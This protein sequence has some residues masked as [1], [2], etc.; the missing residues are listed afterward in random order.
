MGE[1]YPAGRGLGAGKKNPGHD[2]PPA[3]GGG[4]D[5]VRGPAAPGD[6]RVELRGVAPVG[7]DQRFGSAG[8]LFSLW[9][10]AQISPSTFFVGVL[11]TAGFIG[12]GWRLGLVAIVAGNVL[13]S[14][15]VAVLGVLGTRTGAPQL[16]QSRF[17]FGRGV[18]LPAALTWITQIG[19]EA[20]A[21]IFGAE[22]LTVLLGLNYYLGLLVTFAVMGLI[23]VVGYEAIHLFEKLMAVLLGVLFAVVTAKTFLQHPAVTATT[24]GGAAAGGFVLMLAIVFG[25]AVSWGPVSSDYSRYLPEGTSG[26]RIWLA[27]FL[28]LVLGMSWIEIL[29]FGASVLVR[30]V[31]SMAAVDAIMGGG[32]LGDVAMVAMFL[33]TVAILCV[34]DYSGALAAQAAGVPLVR[35]LIT[36]IAAAVAY[37]AAAWLNTGSLGAKFEDVLLLISYWITPWTAIVLLDWWRHSRHLAPGRRRRVLAGPFRSLPMGGR[38]WGATVGLVAGFFACIPFSDTAT[39]S[40]L[41]KDFP[42]LAGYFGGFSSHFLYGGDVAFYTGFVAGGLVYLLWDTLSNSRPGRR[43]LI[44]WRRASAGDE[45]VPGR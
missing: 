13:G 11:G 45:Q 43:G 31:S 19:F 33:G 44:T 26:R 32:A 20:L 41:A 9:F 22:A 10:A 18:H 23:S 28:G 27:S 42:A 7:A 21:A 25:Y 12:L 30:G 40:Q 39:G 37:G 34:E 1:G 35:P 15:T 38:Q 4:R 6:V 29:G 16:Q 3:G 2:V 14:V 8:R 24:H 17:A 36:V 5:E